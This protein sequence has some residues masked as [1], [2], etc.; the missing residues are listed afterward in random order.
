MSYACWFLTGI[1]LARAVIIT[2]YNDSNGI[3]PQPR[4]WRDILTN[5]G[6]SDTMSTDEASFKRISTSDMLLPT[7]KN[8]PNWR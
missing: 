3:L 8:A 6:S 5:G 7:K 1:S 2:A 4:G